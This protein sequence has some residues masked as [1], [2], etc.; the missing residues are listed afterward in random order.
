MDAKEILLSHLRE[1]IDLTSE[2][3]SMECDSYKETHLKKKEVLL[4]AGE[5]SNHMRFIA[6]GSLRAYHMDGSG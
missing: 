3:E 6:A 2:E 5:I 4:F 1:T